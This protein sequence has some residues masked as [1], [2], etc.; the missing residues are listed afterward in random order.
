MSAE[1]TELEQ[2]WLRL[3]QEIAKLSDT[4]GRD[5]GD[6]S[7]ADDCT[8]LQ[9]F[10]PWAVIRQVIQ[11]RSDAAALR[12]Q[13]AE[14]EASFKLYDG[15]MKRATKMWHGAGGEKLTWPSADKMMVWLLERIRLLE[16][17]LFETVDEG[18]V[19]MGWEIQM[20]EDTGLARPTDWP[21]RIAREPC[22]GERRLTC[23]RAEH[24]PGTCQQVEGRA[25]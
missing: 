2:S 11:E 16:K 6:W 5:S 22:G 13:V 9:E 19:P 4:L 3:M 1:R 17:C 15:A 25:T 23:S 8:L 10:D 18:G 14:F 12:E 21:G 24:H 20:D 7:E